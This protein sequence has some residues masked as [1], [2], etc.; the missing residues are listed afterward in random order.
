MSYTGYPIPYQPEED[1]SAESEFDKDK[2]DPEFDAVAYFSGHI[3]AI[4]QAIIRDDWQLRDGLVS[5][6]SL[7][8]QVKNLITGGNGWTGAGPFVSVLEGLT[9]SVD[10]EGADGI[11]IEVS[12]Q[13]ITIRA[14]DLTGQFVPSVNGSADPITI[15]QDTGITV[16]TVDG[17]I[18]VA[19]DF[20]V[21][22]S[23]T[24]V[25]SAITAALVGYAQLG[26]V[27]E[28]TA[29]QY[30]A[31]FSVPYSATPAIDFDQANSFELVLTGNASITAA[32]IHNGQN[33]QI[34][35]AQDGTGGHTVTFSSDFVDANGAE[36]DVDTTASAVTVMSYAV[37]G[38][39]IYLSTVAV[40]QVGHQVGYKATST[41]VDVSTTEVWTV[42]DSPPANTEGEEYTEL[43]TAYTAKYGSSLLEICVH[44][45]WIER[46]AVGGIVGALFRDDE[47]NALQAV[48]VSYYTGCLTLLAV[49]PAGDTDEHTY[50]FRYGSTGAGTVYIGQNTASASLFGAAM[51]SR[52]TIKE[53]RQ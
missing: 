48:T 39:K 36:V 13:T 14:P 27:Q 33:G 31:P 24:A 9:G 16:T 23:L 46:S 52:M 21:V 3:V 10:L 49:V 1:F 34:I 5:Y 20:S 12:G 22:A 42:D 15:A 51:A 45:P 19:V 2:L 29:A 47:L 11:T 18:T 44:I 8:V 25:A 43:N 28:Y 17:T 38:D 40:D 7:S 6:E 53:M 35:I 50:K 4:L 26:E 30:V 37:R 32:S 41:T